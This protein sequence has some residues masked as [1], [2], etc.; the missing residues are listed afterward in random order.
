MTISYQFVSLFPLERSGWVWTGRLWWL[1]RGWFRGGTGGGR[2]R[3][4]CTTKPGTTR[5]SQNEGAAQRKVQ[6]E[7]E[8]RNYWCSWLSK[9]VAREEKDN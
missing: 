3:R 5:I 7:V 9:S 8:E 6:T 1:W 4:G 2:W